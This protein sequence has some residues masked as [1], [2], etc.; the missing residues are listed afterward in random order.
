MGNLAAGERT[1]K[2]AKEYFRIDH[3]ACPESLDPFHIETYHIK[4]QIKVRSGFF[5]RVGSGSGQSQ[6][7]FRN[8]DFN[9]TGIFSCFVS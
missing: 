4:C 1:I 3:T 9:H 6:P 2:S 5:S 7:V 8:P